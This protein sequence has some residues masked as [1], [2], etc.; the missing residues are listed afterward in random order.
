MTRTVG[1][2]MASLMVPTPHRGLRKYPARST[3]DTHDHILQ[4]TLL[5]IHSHDPAGNTTNN[6]S[7]DEINNEIHFWLSSQLFRLTVARV[8]HCSVP[9]LFKKDTDMALR[10]YEVGILFFRAASYSFRCFS[11][12]ASAF[13]RE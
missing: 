6:C 10:N 9:F 3:H 4:Q 2:V 5:R 11:I 13:S 12:S 8:K 1:M 7:S